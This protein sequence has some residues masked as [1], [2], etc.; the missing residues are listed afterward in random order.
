MY[1]LGH[2]LEDAVRQG[3]FIHGLAGDIA[4]QERGED[5]ITAQDILDALPLAVRTSRQGLS[6]T[7]QDRYSGAYVF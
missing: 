1:G 4:A 5:G 6:E 7:L 3:V 2:S